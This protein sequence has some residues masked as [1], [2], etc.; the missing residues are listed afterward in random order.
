M[1]TYKTDS[2]VRR[3]QAKSGG[4]YAS[5]R[6]KRLLST[7]GLRNVLLKE[8]AID[9]GP[10]LYVLKMRIVMLR[11]LCSNVVKGWSVLWMFSSALFI[12]L[13]LM[14]LMR[15]GM[16]LDGVTY[17]AIAKNLSLNHGSIWQPF[18]SETC[19]PVF[20]EHP[21]LAIYLE[22]LFFRV[23]GQQIYVENVYSFCIIG[24]Q[25]SLISWYW[26]KKEK[27]AWYHLAVLL[28]VWVLVPLNT[29]VFTNNMLESTL[30]LFTTA[31]S[32][33]LLRI[34]KTQWADFA[35]LLGASVAIIL[36]F[37]SNGLTALFPLA[38]PVIQ[39]IVVFKSHSIVPS[40]QRTITLILILVL[41]FTAFYIVVP[42]AWQNTQQY[43]LTQVMPSVAGDR[44]AIYTGM[45]HLN[46]IYLYFR[47]VGAVSALALSC[48]VIAARLEQ[49]SIRQDIKKAVSNPKFL[50]FF[51]ISLLASLPVGLS[52][53]QALNYIAQCAPFITLAFTCLCHQPCLVI[54]NH[55]G[56]S[57]GR[58]RILQGLSLVIFVL[59]VSLAIPSCSRFN[60]DEALLKDI[61]VLLPKLKQVSILSTS[62]AVYE[63]WITVAYFSRFSMIGLEQTENQTYYLALKDEPIPTRYRPVKLDL[64]YYRLAERLN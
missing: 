45:K 54:M 21:P 29:R 30:T 14:P 36:G 1:V 9:Q 4:Y 32:L 60:R 53:R 31:A 34:P 25:V 41:M 63:R 26:L 62:K 28:L 27:L 43:I 20:Y 6:C 23:L 15:Q 7:I 61:H 13:V 5:R 33:L 50:L 49:N 44:S 51:Y 64:N 18:Y 48:I 19:F 24:G 2:Y 46:V 10:T 17:A 39:A 38:I 59:V 42:A 8:R 3:A 52:H 55:C 56:K 22:S 11:E 35:Y 58:M 16:F 37:L 47:S 12:L 57:A 40:I